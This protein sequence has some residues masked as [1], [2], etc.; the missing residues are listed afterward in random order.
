MPLDRRTMLK[1]GGFVG[2]ATAIAGSP[3]FAASCQVGPAPHDKGPKVWMDMDQIELDSAYDQSDLRAA[4]SADTETL[5]FEQRREARPARRAEGFSYGA[6]PIEALDVFP[7]KTSNAP[8]FVFVHG[9]AWRSGEAKDYAFPAELFVNAGVNF[10]ALDFIF[11]G[12]ANGDI[13]VM[14]DQVRRLLPGPTRMPRAF[15][16]D[17]AASMSAAIPPAA[18]CAACSDHRLAKGL[19][20]ARRLDQGRPLH[21]RH[22]R[23]EAGSAVKAQLLRQVHRRDGGGDE[24]AAADRE[25]AG[26]DHRDL[27]HQRDARIPAPEPRLRRRGEGGGQAGG[28]YRGVEL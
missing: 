1:T 15:G 23:Y 27:R 5:C 21:E 25:T 16:G 10:V 2:A 17:A 12:T 28:A 4:R 22:L 8:I 14:A 9:G 3:G 7:A 18:I 11:V 6:T 13:G 20:P 26:A 24:L 19:W